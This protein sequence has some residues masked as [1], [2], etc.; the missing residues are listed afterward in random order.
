MHLF[1][2][3]IQFGSGGEITLTKRKSD[4]LAAA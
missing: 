4:V 1:M 3:D 2:D